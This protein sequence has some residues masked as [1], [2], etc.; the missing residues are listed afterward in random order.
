[1]ELFPS[2]RVELTSRLLELW[3]SELYIC[4]VPP[5]LAV[6][7]HWKSCLFS[8]LHLIKS[9]K[10]WIQR[11]YKITTSTYHVPHNS[12]NNSQGVVFSRI[13]HYQGD[14]PFG[15]VRRDPKPWVSKPILL[16]FVIPRLF[17][18]LGPAKGQKQRR[19]VRSD[20]QR[21]FLGLFHEPPKMYTAK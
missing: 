5:V 8:G 15:L 12:A 6:T 9:T 2:S 4:K 10:N 21:E 17:S 20:F 1:M 14:W 3:S 16:C 11:S 19:F 7:P 18:L 13:Q